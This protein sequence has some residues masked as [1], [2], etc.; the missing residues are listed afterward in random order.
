MSH[1]RVGGGDLR[2]KGDKVR[3][4]VYP[5]CSPTTCLYEDGYLLE[6]Q[7][8]KRLAELA[9]PTDRLFPSPSGGEWWRP[10]LYRRI[11][12][13][14]AR[15]AG[16]YPQGASEP[17]WTWHSLGHVYCTYVPWDRNKSPRAVMDA[18]GH[19]SVSVTLHPYGGAGVLERIDTLD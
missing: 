5:E 7:L 4:T 9:S 1:D 3:T 12:N 16:W 8:R 17:T 14:A 6:Q 15:K 19:S 13:P 2:L 18:A 10:H 11:I